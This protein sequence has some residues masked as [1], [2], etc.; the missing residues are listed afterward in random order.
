MFEMSKRGPPLDIKKS[1]FFFNNLLF[2]IKLK[3]FSKF[4]F[5]KMFID[6]G[7]QVFKKLFLDM[8]KVFDIKLFLS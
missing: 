2:F 3:R 6:G 4:I 1:Y 7:L 5:Q 8:T